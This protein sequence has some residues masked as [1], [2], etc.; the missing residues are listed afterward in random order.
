VRR[1]R[2]G[3]STG[4]GVALSLWSLLQRATTERPNGLFA[5]G[6]ARRSLSFA[7]A[8]NHSRAVAGALRA[9]GVGPGS[10]VSWQLTNE[11]DTLVLM[12]AL[13]LVRAVQNPL[14]HTLRERE[15]TFICAQM[16]TELL[17]TTG[18]EPLASVTQ[19]VHSVLPK[20]T[21][22]SILDL[23]AL[24]SP[25]WS[26][27]ATNPVGSAGESAG[28]SADTTSFCFYT[29]GTTADPKGVRH[30]DASVIAAARGM[31]D[32][33]GLSEA[34]RVP[35]VF[36]IAHIGG[37]IHCARALLTGGP[38]LL[39]SDPK[40]A[41]LIPF[42][43]D[44]G[45]TVVPGSP[46]FVAAYFAHL[47]AHPSDAPLFPAARLMNHGGSP[48]PPHLHGA[49][50]DRMGTAGIMSGY[51]L[52]ECPMAVFNRPGD[53]DDVL[54]TTEGRPTGGAEVRIVSP[55]GSDV[56]TGAEGEI[57]IRGPQLTLGYVD[58][59]LDAAAFSADGFLRTGDLGTVDA[60]GYLRV[61]G[62]LKDVIIRNMENV[63]AREIEDLL[64]SHPMLREA[65]V[66]GLPDD[67]TGE[68][69]CVVGIA[70]DPASPPSLQ[71]ITG[72]LRAH[73]L[74]TFKLPEQ[75]ELID[76][77]PTGLLNKVNKRELVKRFAR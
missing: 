40:P 42:L 16:N 23:T 24:S 1:R 72:H 66:I 11:L 51:G 27:D 57:L 21:V 4:F 55:N 62:R 32:A 59:S 31:V 43:R 35:L 48:K 39:S 45:A 69:V 70:R 15:V 77:F 47:D 73:G 71:S 17:V 67:R 56:A 58:R 38:I 8:S 46:P 18:S 22:C 19:A 13:S 54:A 9:R 75:L 3:F 29:S 60:N 76:T 41:N 5:L 34:D 30:S 63:S 50:R 2:H 74:S 26:D 10:V 64:A 33:L 49:V 28:E 14:L 7:D 68:R 25:A 20:I 12:L 37:A 6:P 53:R 65:V 36:P 44:S 61:T 52:T